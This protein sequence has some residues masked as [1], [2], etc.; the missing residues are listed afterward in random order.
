MI[1]PAYTLSKYLNF[2]TVL[3]LF[4][5]LSVIPVTFLFIRLMLYEG[6]KLFQLEPS[7]MYWCK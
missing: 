7:S 2:F 6:I 1:E 3:K 4:V 5:L